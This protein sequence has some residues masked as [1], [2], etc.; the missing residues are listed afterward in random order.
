MRDPAK[1][2]SPSLGRRR[3][4]KAG[5]ALGLVMG[6]SAVAYVRTRGY[7][8]P[9]DRV[10]KAFTPWQFLVVEHAARRLLAPDRPGDASIPTADELDVAGFVDG[11]VFRMDTRVQRDLGR[12]LGY[13]EHVAPLG[14]ACGSRFTRLGA[15]DQDSVL[16]SVEASSTDLLRAGFDGLKSLVL[17]G[18]YR[19]ARTWAIVGYD[20]PLV[21]RPAAGWR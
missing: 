12:F 21:G 14:C 7:E 13:L 16:A 17:M 10:L 9:A 11:W 15:A 6:G 20:G 18:Y 3:L 4:L 1:P 8:L 5:V 2:A 19:D